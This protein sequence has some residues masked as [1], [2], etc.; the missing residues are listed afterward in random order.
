MRSSWPQSPTTPYCFPTLMPCV[1][2][3][4]PHGCTSSFPHLPLLLD[5]EGSESCLSQTQPTQPLPMERDRAAFSAPVCGYR[6]SLCPETPCSFSF[7]FP[8]HLLAFPL[9]LP[10]FSSQKNCPSQE[11]LSSYVFVKPVC[12]HQSNSQLAQELGPVH[13]LTG[14][15]TESK[16]EKL[17]S[18][19]S[20][21]N[22]TPAARHTIPGSSQHRMQTRWGVVLPRGELHVA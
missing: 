11:N 5:L 7:S 20:R 14:L 21:L 1:S 17:S 12:L 13:K 18:S 3:H 9:A 16:R 4:L 8:A 19:S 15:C 6:E 10:H 2:C 22:S